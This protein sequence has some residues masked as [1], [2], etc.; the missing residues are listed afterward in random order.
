M[1]WRS[2]PA[3]DWL[4]YEAR[5]NLFLNS[6]A[7]VTQ[8]IT[9]TTGQHTLWVNGAGS[10]AIAAGTAAIT[11]AGTA[12]NGTPVVINCTVA[13]TVVV[14]IAG[15]LNAVQLEKGAF[16]TSFI[17]T[18]GASAT[19]AADVVTATSGSALSNALLGASG[20]GRYADNERRPADSKQPKDARI[21][22]GRFVS[23]LSLFC[24]DRENGLI[25]RH[26]P[27]I[28]DQFCYACVADKSWLYLVSIWSLHCRKWR[29]GGL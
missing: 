21:I 4:I 11:G 10:A 14:T 2:R 8:T 7:P 5:T 25:Q 29:N 18:A 24:I 27:H 22:N 1:F 3:L 20:A 15:A 17:V 12:T 13:G 28:H 19:R 23:G 16:G 6:T 26:G 9:L